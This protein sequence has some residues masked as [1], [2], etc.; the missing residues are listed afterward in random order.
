MAA[1]EAIF[2]GQFND[3][4]E[5][6]LKAGEEVAA[7]GSDEEMPDFNSD[8]QDSEDYGDDDM[9]AGGDMMGE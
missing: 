5:E 1:A 2:D 8:D 3:L 9:G 6:E 7:A 4:S